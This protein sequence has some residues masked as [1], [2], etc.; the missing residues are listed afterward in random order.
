MDEPAEAQPEAEAPPR[1]PVLLVATSVAM[2][3]ALGV[4]VAVIVREWWQSAPEMASAP[5]P[6]QRP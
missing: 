1:T 6:A 2:L 4:L 3:L 5:A